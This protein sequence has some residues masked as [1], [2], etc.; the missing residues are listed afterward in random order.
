MS[1]SVIVL[2]VGL[3]ALALQGL[4]QR[5]QGRAGDVECHV[6][7]S[8]CLALCW[9]VGRDMIHVS[10]QSKPQGAARS[11]FAGTCVPASGWHWRCISSSVRV[12]IHE[13]AREK[14]AKYLHQEINVWQP[15]PAIHPSEAACSRS[16]I[17][18]F[19]V[20]PMAFRLHSSSI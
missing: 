1:R 10:V 13:L 5:Q 18:L 19:F 2:Q 20:W 4:L 9:N 8:G 14:H 11:G 7:R 17:W 16:E 6:V 12:G 15:M 3:P